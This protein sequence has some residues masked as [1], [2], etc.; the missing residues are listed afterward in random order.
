MSFDGFIKKEAAPA[1]IAMTPEALQEMMATIVREMK[2]PTEI[3]QA[4]IDEEKAFLETKRQEMVRIGRE[5]E[6]QLQQT[7][8]NC[9][10]KKPDGSD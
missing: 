5:T 10:H 3:E 6:I 2:K 1:T 9:T 4:K 7:Q 8:N